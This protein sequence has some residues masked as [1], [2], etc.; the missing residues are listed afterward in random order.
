M[1]EKK[2]KQPIPKEHWEMRYSP[3]AN[4]PYSTEEKNSETLR[5][6]ANHMKTYN[7]VN[8]TDR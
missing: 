1:G 7:K 6:S 5:Q 2:N 8:E 4:V 3:F